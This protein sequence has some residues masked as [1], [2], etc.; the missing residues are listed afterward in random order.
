MAAKPKAMMGR[1]PRYRSEYAEQA[2]K[3]CLMGYTDSQL[4]AFFDVSEA[5]L[6]RWKRAHPEF[7]QAVSYNKALDDV[8]VVSALR[9][10]AVGCT[11][12]K[13]KAIS[14]PR[15]V[16]MHEVE[17]ELP[18]DPAAL[19]MWLYNRQPHL[20][21]KDPQQTTSG[22]SAADALRELAERLP[23]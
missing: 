14:T 3:L 6:Y 11:V 13:Q 21:Q 15:G 23:E 4:W 10:R 22:D 9:R 12:T 17:E 8:E 18:P 2:G 16:E 7:K 19:A 5:T 20:F 1:P